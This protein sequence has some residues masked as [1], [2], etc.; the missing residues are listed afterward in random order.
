M[1]LFRCPACGAAL[2][3]RNARCLCGAELA[4]DPRR[5]AFLTLGPDVAPCA[6]RAAIACQWRAPEPGALCL[7]CAMTRTVPDTGIPDAAELWADAEDA[8]RRV[9]ANLMRWGFF[10]EADPHAPPVFDMLAETG[11]DGVTMGHAAG[12]VTINVAEAD[13][14]VREARRA[15]LAE[16][17]RTMI[18]HF[19]HELG[20]FVFDRLAAAPGFPEAFRAL[21]GDERADYAA[22]LEAHY[23]RHPGSGDDDPPPP[24][25][26]TAYAAAHPHEDWAETFA[27]YLHLVEICDSAAR[28][29]L[30]APALVTAGGGGFDPYAPCPLDALL[31]AA[32]ELGVAL[33][34]V[35]RAMGLADLYPFVLTAPIRAKLGFVHDWIERAAR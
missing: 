12:V 19:R 21:F 27:H 26:L 8:K 20:H 14:A 33:N 7:S 29:G 1:E 15:R 32:A 30:R 23:A 28:A 24:G 11:G 31:D 10:T 35:N 4:F 2:F 16:R 6:N 18:G 9:I 34:H 25:F 17:Y 13:P 5:R 3:F 22:A